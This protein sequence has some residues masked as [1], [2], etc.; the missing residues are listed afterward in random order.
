MLL[1]SMSTSIGQ[2][3]YTACSALQRRLAIAAIDAAYGGGA[4]LRFWRVAMEALLASIVGDIDMDLLIVGRASPEAASQSHRGRRAAAKQ[5]L[6]ATDVVAEALRLFNTARATLFFGA[7]GR[8]VGDDGATF[9]LLLVFV[10]VVIAMSI[11]R[12]TRDARHLKQFKSRIVEG[13]LRIVVLTVSRELARDLF[14][15]VA[16]NVGD[17]GSALALLFVPSLV[18][19]RVAFDKVAEVLLQFESMMARDYYAVSAVLTVPLEVHAGNID[20]VRLHILRS[21]GPFRLTGV[22]SSHM[23][24]LHASRE[25]LAAAVAGVEILERAAPLAL[26]TAAAHGNH[27][28]GIVCRS[29]ICAS[30]RVFHSRLCPCGD[31][32]PIDAFRGVDLVCQVHRCS[33]CVEAIR[34]AGV[35]STERRRQQLGA[36]PA[37][38]VRGVGAG[39][40]GG[41]D[42]RTLLRANL[43]LRQRHCAR[44]AVTA[45]LLQTAKTNAGRAFVLRCRQRDA[46][47]ECL[48]LKNV[49]RNHEN[50]WTAFVELRD[51]WPEVHARR[52]T[53]EH[54][55][56][57]TALL[58]RFQARAD[59]L[60][61]SGPYVAS[62]RPS[63]AL[64]VTMVNADKLIQLVGAEAPPVDH[65]LCVHGLAHA[66]IHLTLWAHAKSSN[67]HMRTTRVGRINTFGLWRIFYM[68]IW[69]LL[70]IDMDMWEKSDDVISIS[71]D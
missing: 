31:A 21:A 37:G 32:Q 19:D 12:I 20:T 68:N 44:D 15:T 54:L 36:R 53:D 33:Q 8:S 25:D 52:P 43:L 24:A 40:A 45:A 17:R 22:L 50:A 57:L 70:S 11:D 6:G 18:R 7:D 64:P 5:A 41:Y 59:E 27:V 61:S 26:T 23:R 55:R 42:A 30:C 3:A 4:M 56:A 28:D 67:C 2:A 14:A 47:R 1:V 58:A 16:A 29:T 51:A 38:G 71:Y 13:Q 69:L 49:R 63:I 62:Q 60:W 46:G 39:A 35:A 66:E 48:V 65:F 10:G 34:A 9:Q